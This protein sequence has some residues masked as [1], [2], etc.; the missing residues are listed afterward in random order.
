VN[1][2]RPLF[3]LCLCFFLACL[4]PLAG[5]QTTVQTAA[6]GLTTATEWFQR[7]GERLELRMQG[8]APFHMKVIFHAFPGMEFLGPKEKSEIVAGDG[9]YE[10][11][12]LSPHKWRREVTLSSYHA[13][14]E[15]SEGVRRMQASSDYEP[16]RVLM[17]LDALLVPIPRNFFSEEF[18]HEGASGWK[19]D[20]VSNANLSLVRVSKTVGSER[21]DLTD[22]F[23]FLPQGMLVIRNFRGLVTEWTSAVLFSGKVVPRHLSIKAGERE[24]LAANISIEAAGPVALAK[25]D[26][27]VGP[28]EPGMTLRPFHDF[29]VRMPDLT[30]SHA[31]AN[32]GNSGPGRA[33][34]LWEVLDRHGRYREVELILVVNKNDADTIMTF[35]REERHHPAEIDG[36]PCELA[37]S[38]GFR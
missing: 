23:Y 16:S 15:E 12:W 13:V 37:V 38:W 29:E 25:L 24:L 31:W 22:A 35:M 34:S 6:P 8:S 7:A 1:P 14:E 9:A 4:P 28:A 20:Q 2:M 11:T 30:F 17:L 10:E 5:L 19:V 26:A 3:L 21:G 27:L 18:R 32:V 33:F 36:S